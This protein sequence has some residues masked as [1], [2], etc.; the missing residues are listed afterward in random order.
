MQ[1]TLMRSLLN[2]LLPTPFILGALYMLS[3]VCV[4]SVANLA[5]SL[6]KFRIINTLAFSLFMVIGIYLK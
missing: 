1:E 2:G 3:L 5:R 4:S 6:L